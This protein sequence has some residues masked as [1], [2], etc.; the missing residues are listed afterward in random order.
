M[1]L[2][3]VVAIEEHRVG[4]CQA[5]PLSSTQTTGGILVSFV[6]FQRRCK[7]VELW[8]ASLTFKVGF[9]SFAVVDMPHVS[10]ITFKVAFILARLI[11]VL[12]RPKK[13]IAIFLL[14][15]SYTQLVWW[16]LRIAVFVYHITTKLMKGILL[17]VSVVVYFWGGYTT[18]RQ[19][20]VE[21]LV[22]ALYTH[23]HAV[24]HIRTAPTAIRRPESTLSLSHSR[25]WVIQFL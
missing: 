1:V 17:V 25:G 16:S 14:R 21:T 23:R 13:S 19:T 4:R 22:K 11:T 10:W 20:G 3:R 8:R 9:Q 7:T 15:Y 2:C 6:K 12:V 5:L 18:S 24:R